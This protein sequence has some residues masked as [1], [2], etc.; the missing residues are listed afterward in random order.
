MRFSVWN[1]SSLAYDYYVAPGELAVA[2]APQPGHLITTT[3]LGLTP[4][5]AA[6]PLPASARKVG[7]GTYP[8]GRI[9]EKKSAITRPALSGTPEVSTPVKI[10]IAIII[11]LV[12]WKS[13]SKGG[14]SGS[15][16]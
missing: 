11:G 16:W 12:A 4:G 3:K 14:A 10:G 7:S 8:K 6:W 5:M 15:W 1:Q 13:L 2:N 9:A